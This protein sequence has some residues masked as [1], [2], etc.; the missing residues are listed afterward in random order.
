MRQQAE[1]Q[2]Q[3]HEGED[4]DYW[5]TA[6]TYFRENRDNY[7]SDHSQSRISTENDLPVENRIDE[8]RK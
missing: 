7:V 6:A 8:R 5:F 4:S 1:N 3:D 2:L